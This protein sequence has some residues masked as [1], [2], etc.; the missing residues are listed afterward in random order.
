MLTKPTVM[1]IAQKIVENNSNIQNN[2]NKTTEMTF[3][4]SP[5]KNTIT[6]DMNSSSMNMPMN[7]GM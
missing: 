4:L 1:D 3:T 5:S 6:G 7:G 2:Q